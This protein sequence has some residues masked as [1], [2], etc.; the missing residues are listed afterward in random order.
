MPGTPSEPSSDEHVK[1]VGPLRIGIPLFNIYLNEADELSRRLMTEVAEWAM[2]LHRPVGEVPIALAHSL[3]GS[4]A[5]VG[6]A[7]LSHLARSLEHALARTQVIGH[8]TDEEARLFVNA[9]EEIRRLLH[10]FAAGFL[11][12]PAPELL[13][14]LAEHE[15]TSALRLEAATA[16]S[17]LAEGQE[18]ESPIEP[19]I[20]VDS[21]L[22]LE[23]LDEAPAANDPRHA[24]AARRSPRAAKARRQRR[25]PWTAP[26]AASRRSIGRQDASRRDADGRRRR[27]RR[28][29]LERRGAGRRYAVVAAVEPSPVARWAEPAEAAPSTFGGLGSFNTLGVAELKPLGAAPLEVPRSAT[30]TAF[31]LRRGR[32]RHR[33]DRR[34]RPR[35]VP[36][37]RGRSAGAAAQARRPAARLAARARGDRR[38]P[39]RACA[40]CTRSRAARVSPARCAWARW[41][42]G[43]RPGS[44]A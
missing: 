37:L 25:R 27:R 33:C 41:R 43:S 32:R 9:A 29:G 17:E 4:S 19:A 23:G 22:S 7:D 13:T 28:A 2:E 21:L 5:T 15:L 39:P 1:V 16:A 18:S 38:T 44:S 8:G 26:I 11:H 24:D 34:G 6:F 14:R 42:T 3:A 12:E 10:Q 31:D 35:A 40:R 20:A 36:D 30:R